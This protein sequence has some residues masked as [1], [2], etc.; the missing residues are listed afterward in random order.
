MFVP[1]L[2][3]RYDCSNIHA[4]RCGLKEQTLL[5]VESWPMSSEFELS[6]QDSPSLT[7]LAV[8]TH[9]PLFHSSAEF[10][11]QGLSLREH[12]NMMYMMD[13]HEE[14][15]VAQ[16][17]GKLPSFARRLRSTFLRDWRCSSPHRNAL[18]TLPLHIVFGKL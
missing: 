11:M 10:S 12:Y 7:A 4:L 2:T 5:A 17:F 18:L 15:V 13:V 8:L 16:L 3:D 9:S 14:L 6:P 1:R